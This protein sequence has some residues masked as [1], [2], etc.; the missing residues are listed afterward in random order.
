MLFS[1]LKESF[2][3][4]KKAMALML[5]SVSMGTALTASLISVSLDIKGKVSKELRAFG[6]NIAVEPKVEGLADLAGQKRHLREED[7]YKVKT[8][9]WRHNIIGIAPFLEEQ[10]V[11][12]AGAKKLNVTV[13]GTWFQK[14]LPLPGEAG[15]FKAGVE[16]V[17]PWWHVE[18]APPEG[19]SLVV[20]AS[21][22]DELG[23]KSGDALYLDE[24]PFTVSGTLSTG[25]PE[26]DKVFMD[27][28]GLQALKGL[29]GKV[30]RVMVSA[31]TTPM[32][33]FA[34]KDP[35][36]MSKKEYEKWYCTGYVTSIAKQVEEVFEGGKAKP[37]WQVA[38]TEG[39]VLERM[40]LLIYLLS[41]AAL[42]ASAL[43]VSTTMVASLLRRLDEI[44]LMKSI[45]ADSLQISLIF[46]FEALIIGFAGGLSGWLI[47]LGAV[48]FIGQAVFGTELTRRALLFPISVL[49][50]LFIATGG[51][52]M[53]IRRALRVKPV[54][55][56]R[57]GR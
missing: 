22:A 49:S 43:G 9:F 7:I 10:A 25:G 12:V 17:S 28:A 4:Q 14:E 26:D 55:V 19:A 38:Q 6:A 27:L 16:T 24:K 40:S 31:V 33:E 23:L 36:S 41:A 18:G 30:S 51:S 50:A 1:L 13:V 15:T 5:L 47:S 52:F 32:D 48:K 57:G 46:L 20:G 37:L 11:L 34:Y 53:P 2:L 54:I 3:R 56:L 21:L 8:V 45:G 44:G 42:M 35:S 29:R 39:R